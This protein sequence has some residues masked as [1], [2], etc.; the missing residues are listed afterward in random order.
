MPAGEE[1]GELGDYRKK[2]LLF[3]EKSSW[4][5]PSR[6]ISDFPFDGE[7]CFHRLTKP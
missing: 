7:F 6:L 5:E 3:L 2:L 4:Y 1:G